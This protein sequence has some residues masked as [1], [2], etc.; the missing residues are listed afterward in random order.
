MR[1]VHCTNWRDLLGLKKFRRPNYGP[2]APATSSFR[3]NL[4]FCYDWTSPGMVDADLALLKKFQKDNDQENSQTGLKLTTHLTQS[5]FL[6]K[7]R[8]LWLYDMPNGI[9]G[10]PATKTDPT[11]LIILFSLLRDSNYTNGWTLSPAVAFLIAIDALDYLSY[12]STAWMAWL[13]D[14][15]RLERRSAEVLSE[16]A[17]KVLCRPG[18]AFGTKLC[19]T[20]FP[21]ERQTLPLKFRWKRAFAA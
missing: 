7:I 13:T 20:P 19:L 6:K 17:A 5:M 10:E 15:L 12:L 3:R 16:V 4:W 8:R 11:A 21:L 2:T 18:H 14:Y 9:V 1:G